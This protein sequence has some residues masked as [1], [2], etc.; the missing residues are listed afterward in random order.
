MRIAEIL[1]SGF[2]SDPVKNKKEKELESSKP[3]SKDMAQVSAEA[4]EL[5]ESEQ[6]RRIREI[7]E[8]IVSGY[9]LRRDISEKVADAILQQLRG[10]SGS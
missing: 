7:E 4:K 2:V 1:G 3:L 6:A 9:Y 10:L 5:F 8:K